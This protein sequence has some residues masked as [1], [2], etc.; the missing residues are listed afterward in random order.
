MAGALGAKRRRLEHRPKGQHHLQPGSSL[1]LPTSHL[2]RSQYGIPTARVQLAAGHAQPRGPEL[3]PVAVDKRPGYSDQ[4]RREDGD[5]HPQQR[6]HGMRHRAQSAVPLL[7][8]LVPD[9]YR[10]LALG[11]D[12]DRWRVDRRRQPRRDGQDQWHRALPGAPCLQGTTPA[13]LSAA[14]TM[15]GAETILYRAP[16]SAPSSS[17]SSRS[18]TWVVTSTPTLRCVRPLPSSDNSSDLK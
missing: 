1:D 12:L 2:D 10:A 5:H 7:T 17:S 14:L 6:F 11:S 9:C 15:D 18:R 3:R 8:Q 4:L 13:G 16:R